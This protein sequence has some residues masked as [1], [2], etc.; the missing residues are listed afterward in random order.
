M[1]WNNTKSAETH[2][3]GIKI[4]KSVKTYDFSRFNHLDWNNAKSAKTH[5]FGIK[6]YKSAET[7]DF[8]RFNH[9][10]WNNT[11]SAK[12]H[13][14]GVKIYKSAE[15]YDFN[16]FNHLDW[17]NTKSAKNTWFQHKNMLIQPEQGFLADLTIWTSKW[18]KKCQNILFV[19]ISAKTKSVSPLFLLVKY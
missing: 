18:Y 16:R 3:F 14:F 7:Y 17:N 2:D 12:T 1:D 6:I 4:Y 15:T 9:L 8:S 11:K 5:D 19:H 10:D 13:N